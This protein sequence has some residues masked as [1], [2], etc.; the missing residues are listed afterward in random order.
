MFTQTLNSGNVVLAK[1]T[2]GS[3]KWATWLKQLL[4]SK[5]RY[6]PVPLVWS[7]LGPVLDVG[8]LPLCTRQSIP[9][10]APLGALVS[11]P[12]KAHT[13]LAQLE[14]VAQLVKASK[15]CT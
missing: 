15:F 2:Q 3:S 12:P 14:V 4:D 6:L 7:P 9:S 8:V 1:F 13:V 5:Y 11:P 10:T